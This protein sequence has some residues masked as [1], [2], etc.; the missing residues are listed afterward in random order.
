MAL[1]RAAFASAAFAVASRSRSAIARYASC[2]S[3]QRRRPG[4]DL[5]RDIRF[6]VDL[7]RDGVRVGTPRTVLTC[8]RPYRGRGGGR[9]RFPSWPDSFQPPAL[10]RRR[11]R[12]SS[13][14]NENHVQ[15]WT[16]LY[17]SRIR[18]S[19]PATTVRSPR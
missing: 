5:P 10:R 13:P 11:V 12:G 16:W 15:Y 9:G 17:Q 6:V 4:D 1:P 3:Q 2:G 7:F 18:P 14:T 8:R 19:P